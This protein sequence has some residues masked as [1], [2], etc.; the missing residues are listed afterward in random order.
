MTI[1]LW[2]QEVCEITIEM[3]WMLMQK[4]N[5]AGNDTLNNNE[6][7][8]SKSFEYKTKIIG[9][10]PDNSS[11]LDAEVVVPLEYL[12]NFWR[13]LNLPFINCKVELHMSWPRNCLI[14]K[15]SKTPERVTNPAA[16]P[17]I[18]HVPA[19]LT[20]GATFQILCPSSYFVYTQ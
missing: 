3:K 20:T 19:R 4:N 10:T 16:N 6:K 1:V 12:N 9:R 13:S 8:T 17:A 2:H 5:D 18:A 15:I 7:T 11:R 14:S